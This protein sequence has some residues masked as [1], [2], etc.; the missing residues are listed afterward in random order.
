MSG[1][2][3]SFCRYGTPAEAAIAAVK[4]HAEPLLLD[5]DETL[6]LRNSTEDFIDT[7]SPGL[8]ALLLL[9]VLDV[10]KPWRW[11]GGEATRDVWRVRLIAS[12][13]PWIW[14]SW[15]RRTAT[16]A[17]QHA[18]RA[19]LDKV[20]A[21]TA[22]TLILTVGFRRIVEPLVVALGL[23]RVQIVAARLDSFSDRRRG[24]FAMAVDALGEDLVSRSM[25]LTD[26][27]DDQPLLERCALPMLTVWPEARYEKALHRVYLPGQYLT[28]VK[29]PGQRY[30]VRGILQEDYAFWILSSIGAAQMPALHVLGMLALLISFWAIYERGYV[31]NDW[32]AQRYEKDPKL[33]ATFG[34]VEVATPPLQPWLWAAGAGVVA[35]FLLRWPDLMSLSDAAI[36]AGVL[37]ATHFGF[38]MYNR[39]DKASRIWLFPGLQLARS[40]SFA[41][42]VPIG[43]AASLAL[44]AHVIARWVPYYV[45]RIS[46]K[47]WPE[48]PLFVSR[49]MF[50]GLLWLMVAVTQGFDGLLTGTALALL[51]WNLFR[52]R[53]ELAELFR[54]L[55][56]ID[57]PGPRE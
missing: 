41:L 27:L 53:R 34:R 8:L 19:L 24:K 44:G 1:T 49:L 16:L 21:R 40:A 26:S 42:L 47:N 46:D 2:A 15:R 13:F 11:T 57:R 50:Y 7:A 29:R 35:L 28:Q 51:G 37:L 23:T 45:Y 55:H 14:G 5:L 18:N 43:L 25:V 38:A 31:D 48:A 20:V 3:D 22:P 54:G 6:Y 17:R 30:I 36:W 32:I 56:R 10:I 39:C 33:S 4:S 9:R 52:A 12:C